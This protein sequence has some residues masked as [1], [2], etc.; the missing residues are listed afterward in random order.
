MRSRCA[1]TTS[2]GDTSRSLMRAARSVAARHT[3][4]SVIRGKLSLAVMARV[5]VSAKAASFT[6]SVIRGMTRL[7]LEHDAINLAQGFPDFAAPSELKD[8]ACAA[9][10]PDINRY[11][12]T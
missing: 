1:S 11:A 8:A 6:E 2:T 10:A 12:I 5:H 4:S 7:A 9:V 3:R